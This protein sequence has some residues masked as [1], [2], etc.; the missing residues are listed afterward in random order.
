MVKRMMLVVAAAWVVLG[1]AATRASAQDDVTVLLRSGERVRGELASF[2]HSTVDIRDSGGQRRQLSWDD[3]VVL[4]FVGGASGLPRTETDAVPQAEHVVFL[5]GGDSL[6]GR[7]VDFVREGG[8]DAAVVFAADDGQRQIPLDRVGRI[9]VGPFTPEASSVAGVPSA[10]EPGVQAGASVEPNRDGSYAVTVPG[11][12]RW[13]PTGIMVRKGQRVGFET[14]GTIYLVSGAQDQAGAAGAYTGR[15]A[16]G[17]P[18]PDQLV[19][20]FIGRVGPRGTPFGIGDQDS[21]IMPAS[22]E[23]F[24]GINDDEVSDNQGAFTVRVTP[25]GFLR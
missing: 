1:V 14:D 11:T 19:G 4:D 5:K 24:L 17:A 15:R 16:N 9:Y 12:T 23:L 8:P 10:P 3:V 7:V 6:R 25:F 22:G 13:M 18:L 2:D 20:A 21:L